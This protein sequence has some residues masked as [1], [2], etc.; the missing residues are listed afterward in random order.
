[1]KT[2]TLILI[3]VASMA[4]IAITVG[5]F[6]ESKQSVSE[7]SIPV[8][9]GITLKDEKNLAVVEQ[10]RPLPPTPQAAMPESSLD[11]FKAEMSRLSDAELHRVVARTGDEIKKRLAADP[12]GA[13][14]SDADT[15]EIASELDR[16]AAARLLLIDRS[17]DSVK[18][19]VL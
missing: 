18:G 14:R 12:T 9:K 5:V 1:M 2:R 4:S 6:V 15:K 16:E 10:A 8:S 3:I 11:A 19:T 17:L 13:R 7:Q